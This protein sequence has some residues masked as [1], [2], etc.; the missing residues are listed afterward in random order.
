MDEATVGGTLDVKSVD[1]KQHEPRNIETQGAKVAHSETPHV[2]PR[3]HRRPKRPGIVWAVGSRLEARD[4]L[5]KWY[6]AYDR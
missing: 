4:F 2:A 5:N 1:A 6:T 3:E